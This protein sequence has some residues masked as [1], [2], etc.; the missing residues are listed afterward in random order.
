[1]PSFAPPQNS[2]NVTYTGISEVTYGANKRKAILLKGQHNAPMGQ[3]YKEFQVL[4]VDGFLGL[5]A[6][7]S[8]WQ[9]NLLVQAN[10]AGETRLPVPD[11]MSAMT[12]VAMGFRYHEVEEAELILENNPL[13]AA[14]LQEVREKKQYM[15]ALSRELRKWID[16]QGR[17]PAG[18]IRSFMSQGLE[19][20]ASTTSE[21]RRFLSQYRD[22]SI[23]DT[24]YL[25]CDPDA[26]S[27]M[28]GQIVC[29][30]NFVD[31][32][33]RNPNFCPGGISFN[34]MSSLPVCELQLGE[35]G[36]CRA[37]LYATSPGVAP[38]FN[39][40]ASGNVGAGAR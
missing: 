19:R 3:G 23:D 34:S 18:Q 33:Q 6:L 39:P 40:Q 4:D 28:I 36:L 16:N 27:E 14:V 2:C 15:H 10:V 26:E 7:H 38:V 9:S 11:L 35:G 32:R 30:R 22:L 8:A 25:L 12:I 1:M 31:S 21:E 29:N 13:N 17:V 20:F 24:P 5:A 37:S